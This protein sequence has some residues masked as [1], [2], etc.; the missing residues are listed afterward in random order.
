M[1]A[2]LV[3]RWNSVTMR[4]G[5]VGVL[6]DTQNIVTIVTDRH[7]KFSGVCRECL[8][9]GSSL[10]LGE[11]KTCLQVAFLIGSPVKSAFALLLTR[12]TEPRLRRIRK[13]CE[14]L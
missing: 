9:K 5:R 11:R 1:G 4:D 3:L 14:I 10:P 2:G 6:G 7:G 8:F 13:G 12:V